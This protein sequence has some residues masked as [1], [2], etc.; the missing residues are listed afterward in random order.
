MNKDR[1]YST[2]KGL[3]II[4]TLLLQLNNRRTDFTYLSTHTIRI[5]LDWL[6]GFIEGDGGFYA[7]VSKWGLKTDLRVSQT[8]AEEKLMDAIQ[9]YLED[10]SISKVGINIKVSRSLMEGEAVLELMVSNR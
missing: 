7:N 9:V 3:N 5:I 2:D 1:L 10:L 4:T 8:V 6:I